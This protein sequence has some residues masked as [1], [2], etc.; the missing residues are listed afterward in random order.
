MKTLLFVSL[1]LCSQCG[2]AQDWKKMYVTSKGDTLTLN[3]SVNFN[4][5]ATRYSYIHPLKTFH[6]TDPLKR[7]PLSYAQ[8]R[9]N[10]DFL[11]IYMKGQTYR[12]YR[13]TRVPKGGKYKVFATVL[14]ED[15]RLLS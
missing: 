7:E 11:N 15:A 10:D 8:Y 3:S 5:T 14:K 1:F 4:V 9:M 2:Y 6:T 12:I 13:F